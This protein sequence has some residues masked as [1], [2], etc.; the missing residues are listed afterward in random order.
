MGA[1]PVLLVCGHADT[2]D[3][4]KSALEHAGMATSVTQTP[5]AA[6][7]LLKE[8]QA[9]TVVVLIGPS[10]DAVAIGR[11]LR[12]EPGSADATLLAL[13]SVQHRTDTLR[14]VL[15]NFDDEMLIPCTPDALMQ[16]IAA[17]SRERHGPPTA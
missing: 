10:D 15:Q 6:I 4:Y 5:D 9:S 12:E 14:E 7:A 17:L 8:R 2:A 13:S 16:R 3:L 1:I 11:A